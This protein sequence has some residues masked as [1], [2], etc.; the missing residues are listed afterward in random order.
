[1]PIELTGGQEGQHKQVEVELHVLRPVLLL[2]LLLLP[3]PTVRNITHIHTHIIRTVPRTALVLSPS[4]TTTATALEDAVCAEGRIG[5][6]VVVV[7]RISSEEFV[8]GAREPQVS[9]EELGELMGGGQL[10]GSETVTHCGTVGAQVTH[11]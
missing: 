3:L 9:T 5:A 6:V 1:M 7:G 10:R 2:L 11:T 8:Y 4:V